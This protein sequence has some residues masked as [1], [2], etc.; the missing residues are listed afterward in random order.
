MC[1]LIYTYIIIRKLASADK[2]AD[3]CVK[4]RFKDSLFMCN[5]SL[6]II[7]QKT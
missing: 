7:I 6:L 5:N 3:I 1:S 4:L 2:A